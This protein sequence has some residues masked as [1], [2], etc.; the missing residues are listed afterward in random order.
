MSRQKIRRVAA[1]TSLFCFALLLGAAF[2]NAS[3]PLLGVGAGIAS[4]TMIYGAIQLLASAQARMR[5][6]E[7]ASKRLSRE[8][9]K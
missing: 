8:G 2:K 9:T 3:D 4:A 7:S 6:P 1:A 5:L